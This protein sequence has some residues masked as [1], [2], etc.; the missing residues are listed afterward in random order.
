MCSLFLSSPYYHTKKKREHIFA[1]RIQ[2]KMAAPFFHALA[3]EFE[4]MARRVEQA[5]PRKEE[6]LGQP[7]VSVKNAGPAGL[8]QD[9]EFLESTDLRRM[10]MLLDQRFPDREQLSKLLVETGAVVTGG[11]VVQA[12]VPT[13]VAG[14]V[15][16]LCPLEHVELWAEYLNQHFDNPDYLD[17]CKSADRSDFTLVEYLKLEART[18]GDDL[19]ENTVSI[20]WSV[21]KGKDIQLILT[22]APV[23]DVIQ[24]FD[25]DVCRVFFDGINL[26]QFCRLEAYTNRIATYDVA[27]LRRGRIEKYEK[28]GFKVVEGRA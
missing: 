12:M 1:N 23:M 14:D 20:Y 11:L 24:S 16:I 26:G 22:L 6:P 18:T 3:N 5:Q 8:E 15:D 21:E 13:A 28:K 2:Q 10:H 27:K 9:A 4:E 17:M 7:E 19:Y 25:L